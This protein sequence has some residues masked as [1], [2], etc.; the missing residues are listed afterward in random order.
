[1]TTKTTKR[2]KDRRAPTVRQASIPDDLSYMTD[3]EFGRKMLRLAAEI[4]KEQGTR[5][6]EEINELVDLMPGGASVNAD[7]P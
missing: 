6:T 5:T 3:T 7:L 4:A 1:M 2:K